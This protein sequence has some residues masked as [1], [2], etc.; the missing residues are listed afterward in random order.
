MLLHLQSKYNLNAT[1][2][3]FKYKPNQMI[4]P[5]RLLSIN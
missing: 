5:I 4:V 3:Q 1:Q 2:T